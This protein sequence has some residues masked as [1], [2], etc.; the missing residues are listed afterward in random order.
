[1]NGPV[2]HGID[3]KRNRM[4]WQGYETEST[5]NEL[6]G[7]GMEEISDAAQKNSADSK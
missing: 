6:R 2:G 5:C 3:R 4:E 7:N 1:M